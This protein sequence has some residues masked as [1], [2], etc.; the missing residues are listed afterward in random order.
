MASEFPGAVPGND[1]SDAKYS[2]YDHD[3]VHG[4]M[5]KR[6]RID[7]VCPGAGITIDHTPDGGV[8]GLNDHELEGYTRKSISRMQ[9]AKSD[10]A[11]PDSKSQ[12]QAPAQDFLKQN[13]QDGENKAPPKELFD[14]RDDHD[15]GEKP[16]VPA[17]R[18]TIS[19]Q[20]QESPY[21]SAV[22]DDDREYKAP[23]SPHLTCLKSKK[24]GSQKGKCQEHKNPWSPG[25][26]PPGCSQPE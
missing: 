21:D 20:E 2:E 11:E 13:E 22:D 6:G 10:S 12:T 3:Q 26:D 9:Q 19:T 24:P 8:E 23:M 14:E 7:A 5:C 1:L 17:V 18:G 15:L 4:G 16:L 25:N